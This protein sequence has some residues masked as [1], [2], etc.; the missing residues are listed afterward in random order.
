MSAPDLNFRAQVESVLSELVKVATVELTKLFE[1]HY[2]AC[3]V[4]TVKG[5]G[6][7]E[8]LELVLINL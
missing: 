2:Q 3:V 5:G 4:S 8:T 1:T 6:G 7:E